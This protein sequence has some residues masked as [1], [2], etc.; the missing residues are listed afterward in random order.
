MPAISLA[1]VIRKL[2][3]LKPILRTRAKP[4]VGSKD[5]VK[6]QPGGG[7]IKE[8]KEPQPPPKDIQ[9]QKIEIKAQSK[10]GSLD[11]VKHKPGGGEKKIFDD[12]DYLK[13]IE[14]GVPITT[15]PAQVTFEF[16]SA[17]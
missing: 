1:V 8:S 4:K 3:R 12:K 9:T 6:H 17:H 13:N 15:P 7:D 10:I 5:N 14:H 16:Y 11:N 2:K